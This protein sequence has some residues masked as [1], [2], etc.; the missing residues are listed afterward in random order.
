MQNKIKILIVD[1][2]ADMR[3]TL[4]TI[5]AQKG[6]S[7]ETAED[8]YEALL[9]IKEK[10]PHIV[11]LDI[12]MPD[13][14]GTEIFSAIKGISPKTK[15]IIY[16]GMDRYEHSKYAKAADKFLL[17]GSESAEKLL[18]LIAELAGEPEEG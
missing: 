10:P 18:R 11:I 2:D 17:K 13:K 9:R 1:D 12:M 16:T 4:K 7:V 14:N 3:K 8:G 5:L 15:V 6:Y